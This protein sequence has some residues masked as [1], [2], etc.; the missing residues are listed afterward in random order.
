MPYPDLH[1][2]E[3]QE[4]DMECK[5][6]RCVLQQAE[7]PPQTILVLKSCDGTNVFL[8]SLCAFMLVDCPRRK[9]A[10]PP[11]VGLNQLIALTP[12][13]DLSLIQEFCLFALPLCTD[14][15]YHSRLDR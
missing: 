6:M 7:N 1:G 10:C 8:T 11:E 2:S 14:A 13:Q 15:T 9:P 5:N 4:G 3:S 12:R